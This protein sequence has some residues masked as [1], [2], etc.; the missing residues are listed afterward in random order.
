[1]KIAFLISSLEYG[2]AERQLIMLA[3]GLCR[4]NNSVLIIVFYPKGEL[5]KELYDN[6]IKVSVISLD[7]RGR[8]QIIGFIL[9]LVRTLRQQKPDILHSYLVVSNILA[10]VLKPIFPRIRMVW[11][12]RSTNM[13]LRRY[14]WRVR[15]TYYIERCLSSFADLIIA[16][17]YAGR[18]YAVSNGFPENRMVVISNGIDTGYFKPD[19]MARKQVRDVWSISEHKKLIG[20][21]GRIDPM[22]DHVTFLKAAAILASERD[23]VLFVCVGDGPDSYKK[24]LNFLTMN[25]GIEKR[26]FWAGKC[27][28]MPAMYNALDICCSSSSFGE[29]FS[30]VIGEAMAC[31]IPC[32]VTDVG[33]SA[34]IVGDTGIVVPPKSPEKLAEGLRIMIERLK[35]DN[36]LNLKVR[37]RIVSEFSPDKLVQRTVE[38]LAGIH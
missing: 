17:S 25:L 31:G 21:V 11:G 27:S 38:E 28:E 16:N 22:K 3:K 34:M 23:D 9:R 24:G 10:V 18:N 12:V 29:G 1:M 5:A 4:L 37:K 13:D 7:K 6:N 32:V 35:E 19:V 15:L 36:Y 26:F 14:D 30:N 8:W 33:D 2:G 20:L